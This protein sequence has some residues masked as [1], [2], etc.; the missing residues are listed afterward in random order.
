MISASA[1]INSG[2]T[3]HAPPNMVLA[4]DAAYGGILHPGPGWGIGAG[5]SVH[6]CRGTV[7]GYS[8]RVTVPG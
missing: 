3:M 4:P 1:M 7:P 8:T 5:V 2:D 6:R